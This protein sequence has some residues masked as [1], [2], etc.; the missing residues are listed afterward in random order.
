MQYNEPDVSQALVNSG[1]FDAPAP[2]L[3]QKKMNLLAK[4]KQDKLNNMAST[5]VLDNLYG[6]G[7]STGTPQSDYWDQFQ[8]GA[9]RLGR[10]TA[11]LGT[12]ILGW[13]V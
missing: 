9:Y 11:Q 10:D 8:A 7:T 5:A 6:V 2:S 4:N 13:G 12:D 3:A 1:V